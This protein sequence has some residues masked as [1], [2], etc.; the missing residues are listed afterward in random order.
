MAMMGQ[1]PSGNIAESIQLCLV[2][3]LLTFPFIFCMLQ[4]CTQSGPEVQVQQKEG[5]E[6]RYKLDDVGTS[7]TSIALSTAAGSTAVSM[8]SSSL[9]ASESLGP[10]VP[11]S[12]LPLSSE[13]LLWWHM[14]AN[15]AV[16]CGDLYLARIELYLGERGPEEQST[17]VSWEAE[18]ASV[19]STID[20]EPPSQDDL[21]CRLNARTVE[22]LV[23][24]SGASQFSTS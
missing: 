7:S 12:R 8:T 22:A 3:L 4:R 19:A 6:D 10:S 18:N 9:R 1:E 15:S 14:R 23:R 16:S 11:L 20:G 21:A 13:S 5:Q 17:H 24:F 2:V